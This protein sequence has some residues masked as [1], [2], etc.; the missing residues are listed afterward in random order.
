[1]TCR[2]PLQHRRR[3]HRGPAR[4]LKNFAIRSFSHNLNQPTLP[5]DRPTGPRQQCRV[6]SY[7]SAYRL[8]A[9]RPSF[10]SEWRFLPMCKHSISASPNTSILSVRHRPRYKMRRSHQILSRTRIAHGRMQTELMER[11]LRRSVP[12][13]VPRKD[14]LAGC[15]VPPPRSHPGNHQLTRSMI[16][17]R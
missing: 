15:R 3:R 6:D 5:P 8:T 2:R 9:N 4:I 1:M 16:G 13:K 14:P 12:C 17:N 7:A 11:C 10:R